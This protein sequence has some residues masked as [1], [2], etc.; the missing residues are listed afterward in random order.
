M[1]LFW[2]V[3]LVSLTMIGAAERA[4]AQ[5]GSIGAPP[6]RPAAVSI[7]SSSPAPS[8]ARPSRP[9]PSSIGP[10]LPGATR[11]VPP[12]FAGPR[13]SRRARPLWFGLVTFDR[14]WLWAPI[15]VDGTADGPPLPAPQP[16]LVGGLQLDIEPRRAL[17]Y[18]DGWYVGI[19]DEFSGYYR[20]LEVPAGVHTFGIVATDYEPLEF[21]L[22][23]APGRTTTYR[24]AL[25]RASGRH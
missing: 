7:G 1:K 25:Q 2:T 3:T 24:G 13:G 8:R 14:S 4:L 9:S 19:V 11:V 23:I 6:S 17:V 22:T 10:L 15:V 12:R 20:H 18:V 21:D 16:G 5:G